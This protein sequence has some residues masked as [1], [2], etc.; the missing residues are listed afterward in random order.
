VPRSPL[1]R[2][3]VPLR[4]AGV[5]LATAALVTIGGCSVNAAPPARSPVVVGTETPTS[6]AELSVSAEV[7]RTRIDGARNSIQLVVHNRSDSPLT[8]S[9]ARLSSPWLSSELE[10]YRQVTVPPRSQ[11][12]LPMI[13][14]APACPSDREPPTPAEPPEAVLVVPLADG[15]S[16]SLRVP[17]TD[18]IGQWTEWLVTACFA[19]RVGRLVELSMRSAP[20]ETN[21]VVI[22]LL[23]RSIPSSDPAPTVR[24]ESVSGTVLLGAVDASGDPVESIPLGVDMRSHSN[25]ELKAVARLTFRPN[26]CDAHALA[27]DKQGTL[28]RVSASIDGSPGAL[29]VIA[30]S[31]TKDEIYAAIARICPDGG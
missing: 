28:F 30:D 6:V 13:L 21:V 12:D 24:L 23:A 17:T 1:H 10:R 11:R 7:Y 14:S 18:R 2:E 15:S 8:F 26:R 4:V 29:T 16:E 22:D 27:D 9:S 31:A 3:R 20:G 5:A 19:E 25:A